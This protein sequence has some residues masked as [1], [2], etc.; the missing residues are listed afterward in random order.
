MYQI[1]ATVAMV[2]L[3]MRLDMIATAAAGPAI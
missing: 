3:Q 2:Q 1:Q